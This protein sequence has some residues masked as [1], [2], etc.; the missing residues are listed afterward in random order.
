[1]EWILV[2]I[3]VVLIASAFDK[4]S[5]DIGYNYQQGGPLFTKAERSFLGVLEQ[6]I[7]NEYR[8]FAKVR[9]AD[10][11]SPSKG[12]DRKT[13]QIAFNKISSK[14]FDYVLC[15]K[16]TLEIVAVIEL[17]DKSH[18]TKK[19]MDRDLFLENACESA[20]LL[21]IRFTAKAT[22]KIHEIQE[23]LDRVLNS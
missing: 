21:L 17:D 19:R 20:N 11:L 23:N 8:V 22:Y 12:K 7:S 4:P 5:K 15:Q 9:V 14:H 16:N 6:S 1:M 10:I 18:K 2:I 3:V 13:W